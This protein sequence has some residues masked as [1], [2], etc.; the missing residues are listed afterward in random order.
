MSWP[1]PL[2][3]ND[4]AYACRARHKLLLMRP[5]GVINT[6]LRFSLIAKG[7]SQDNLPVNPAGAEQGRVQ[8][9]NPV[10]GH[11]DLD[12]QINTIKIKY[13]LTNQS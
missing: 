7:L 3:C 4:Q 10:G 8:N 12:K 11:D 9:V 13:L 6:V 5:E 2:N 1:A